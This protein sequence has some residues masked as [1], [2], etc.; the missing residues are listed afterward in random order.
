MSVF[1][2]EIGLLTKMM[3]ELS[4]SKAGGRASP[5]FAFKLQKQIDDKKA[6]QSQGA[7]LSNEQH[8]AMIDIISNFP[9]I[10]DKVISL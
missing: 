10:K 3:L 9:Y 5:D 2:E 8:L 4:N 7:N 1:D 6:K